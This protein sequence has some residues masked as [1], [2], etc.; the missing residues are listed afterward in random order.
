MSQINESQAATPLIA[1]F[2]QSVLVTLIRQ[3]PLTEN[4]RGGAHGFSMWDNQVWVN[5]FPP[6]CW[7]LGNHVMALGIL[8]VGCVSSIIYIHTL[9]SGFFFFWKAWVELPAAPLD[10][11]DAQAVCHFLRWR[12]RKLEL[13]I[14]WLCAAS[15]CQLC[16][17]LWR[18]YCPLQVVVLSE[19][20]TRD[21]TGHGH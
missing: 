7:E 6:T 20:L 9:L 3:L 1:L 14:T 4:E 5:S 2:V 15:G 13:L 12:A 21:H 11:P 8:C 19:L 10:A 16:S 18:E 17:G